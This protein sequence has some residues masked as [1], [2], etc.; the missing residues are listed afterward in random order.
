MTEFY[1]T[2]EEAVCAAETDLLKRGYRLNDFGH[3]EK[4]GHILYLQTVNVFG[5]IHCNE[6]DIYIEYEDGMETN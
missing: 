1:R 5:G 6:I 4:P 3:W 2:S